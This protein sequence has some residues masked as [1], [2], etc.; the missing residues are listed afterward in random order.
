MTR[1][2]QD[3]EYDRVTVT[4]ILAFCVLVAGLSLNAVLAEVRSELHLSATMT[5]LHGSMFGIG[6]LIAGL[7]G[8]PVVTHVGRKKTLYLSVVLT[9]VGMTTFSAGHRVQLTLLGAGAI[10]VGAAMIVMVAPGIIADHHGEQR[11]AALAAINGIPGLVAVPIAIAL[12]IVIGAGA[13]WRTPYFLIGALMLLLVLITGLPA[14]LPATTSTTTTATASELRR[15][16]PVSPINL[17]IQR[18]DVRWFWFITMIAV[19]TE[20]PPGVWCSTYLHEVGGAS[21]G[22]ASGLS[23]VYGVGLFCSRM[24][25]P[26]LLRRFGTRLRSAG[27]MTMAV[28]AVSLWSV[29]V[30]WVRVVALFIMGIGAGPLYPVSI[31]DLFKVDGVDTVALGAVGAL[32]SGTAITI[33]PLMFG[34][35]ADSISLRHA[36][37][38][39]PVM[40]LTVI[41]LMRRHASAPTPAIIDLAT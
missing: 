28:S 23:C 41:A 16:R 8:R 2:Q 20:F 21:S 4:L 17:L 34:V 31:D 14:R 26:R 18:P 24:F 9:F 22:L 29:P 37:L 11:G 12:G 7:V 39:V 3:L 32:A 38:V 15:E 25:L 5:T 30:L 13:S 6:L 33:G 36:A 27:L 1:G 10:A 35:I 40:A 19:L